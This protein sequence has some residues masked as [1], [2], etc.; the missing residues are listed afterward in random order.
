MR[1]RAF[2]PFQRGNSPPICSHEGVCLGEIRYYFLAGT[3]R[4]QALGWFESLVDSDNSNGAVASGV[5]EQLSSFKQ[6]QNN[7][8]HVSDIL[9]AEGEGTNA[10]EHANWVIQL[11]ETST[12]VANWTPA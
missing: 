6:S 3:K 11:S 9:P 12:L 8:A 5:C 10:E 7:E 2:D 4:C 1:I